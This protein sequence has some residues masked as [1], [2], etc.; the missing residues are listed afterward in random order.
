MFKHRQ[1]FLWAICFLFALAL[2]RLAFALI[3]FEEIFEKHNSVMLLIDPDSGR[4]LDANPAAAAFY[5]YSR[6]Q[7]RALKIQHINQL[8]A[9][10]VADERELAKTEGRNY[11]IFRHQLA[12]GSVRTVEVYSIPVQFDGRTVLFSSIHDISKERGVEEQL[13]HYQTQ[14]EEMVDAQTRD[15][16]INSRRSIAVLG[17]GAGLMFVMTLYMLFTLR[18][19]KMA[20]KALAV[21]HQ[22]VLRLQRLATAPDRD[23]ESKVNALLEMGCDVFGMPLGIV[24]RIEGDTYTVMYACSPNGALIPGTV[25][26][27]NNTYCIHTLNSDEPTAFVNVGKS[28]IAEHPCYKGFGLESYIGIQ[29]MVGGKRYGTLN[30]SSFEPHLESFSTSEYTLIRLFAEWVEN[31]LTRKDYETDIILA[32]SEAD[33]ASRAKSEFLASMSHEL[34][35]PLNSIIGF[36]E[37]MKYEIKGPLPGAYIEYTGFITKSGKL[38]LETVNSILDLAKIEADKFEL[39]LEPLDMGDLVDEVFDLV[40]VIALEKGIELR[41][42][43]SNLP[44]LNVDS[45]RTK[46]VLINL[47]NNAVK[48]TDR[49]HVVMRNTHDA[50]GHSITISDTGIG[51]TKDQVEVALMPFKQI[52]GNSLSR[53]YQGTG[54]GLSLSR[55]IMELLG[56]DLHVE[57]EPDKGTTVF[58]HFPEDIVVSQQQPA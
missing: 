3:G 28:E 23:F 41:N 21:N 1:S 55:K 34:R 53:R 43:T 12:D 15:I 4:I 29:L 9:S 17:I 57:S 22:S 18:K 40:A 33:L 7:L 6:D 52:H 58:L 5:G 10:Q 39:Y 56:G 31:E 46:Q 47:L 16:Q 35:T 38:L 32:K 20:E 25:Y 30:F 42:E 8:T 49:G 44:F 27:L 51:M 11:F 19:R 2:P 24:S 45:V 50:T 48:F 13:W 54:L 37:M 14:L 36:A 26:D